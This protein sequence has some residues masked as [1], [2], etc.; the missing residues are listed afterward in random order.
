M[1][2]LAGIQ[3]IKTMNFYYLAPGPSLPRP[4]PWSNA[5]S[6]SSVN[7]LEKFDSTRADEYARQCRIALAR[8]ATRLG[9]P[10]GR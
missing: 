3:F 6:A 9:L 1:A 4:S 5:V 7:P 2:F 8:I 10:L